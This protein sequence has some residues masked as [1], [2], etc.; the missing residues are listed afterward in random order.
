MQS[1]WLRRGVWNGQGYKS[2]VVVRSDDAV[3]YV[4]FCSLN[5]CALSYRMTVEPFEWRPSRV[6]LVLSL[7][8]C[9]SLCVPLLG[10]GKRATGVDGFRKNGL[11]R[12]MIVLRRRVQLQF[13]VSPMTP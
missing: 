4:L 2:C 13:K 8:S 3:Q 12:S 7:S 5:G 11:D 1:E 10:R 6:L 9:L